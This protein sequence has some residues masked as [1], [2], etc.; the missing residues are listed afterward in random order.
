MAHTASDETTIPFGKLKEET[1]EQEVTENVNQG[2]GEREAELLQDLQRLQ[3]EYVNYR[4]RVDRD[5]DVSRETA[6]RATLTSLLP[7][8]DD[9]DAAREFGDL[10]EGPFRSIADKLDG[11]LSQLGMVKVNE[12]DVAF[13]PEIHEAVIT[14][15][16]DTVKED[17]VIRVFRSGYLIGERTVRAA[18]VMVSNG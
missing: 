17:N 10:N 15:P 18:Q 16:S 8:L 3:A 12:V 2:G 13:N 7:V 14:Q 11:I 5:R 6:I 4:K 1:V 9:I